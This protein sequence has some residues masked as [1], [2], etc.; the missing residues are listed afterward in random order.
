MTGHAAPLY[1]ASTSPRRLALLRAAGIAFTVVHPGP[2]P[3]GQGSPRERCMLRAREKALHASGFTAPGLVL[4]VD[5]IVECDGVELD[6]PGD[7]EVARATLR[8]LAGR[9][10]FVHTAHCLVVTATGARHERLVSAIVRCANLDEATLARYVA[11]REWTDKA[12][13]YGI[14]GAAGAFITLVGGDLDTVVGLSI[15]AVRELL[16]RAEGR[17]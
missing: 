2:E 15:A 11:T 17:A 3:V 9:E 14:Q 10:H 1:L 4:G 16:A 8:T 13:G 7:A 6:K 5:T 12:G